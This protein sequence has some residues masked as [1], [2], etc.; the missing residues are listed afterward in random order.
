MLDY[1]IV[2]KDYTAWTS[3][4]IHLSVTVHDRTVAMRTL[5][6]FDR[7]FSH[8]SVI[9]VQMTSLIRAL[10]LLLDGVSEAAH[11]FGQGLA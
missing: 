6:Q 2:R 8:F 1:P 9:R 5:V 11:D 4:A 10:F 7:S 3:T